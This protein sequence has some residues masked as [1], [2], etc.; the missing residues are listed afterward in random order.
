MYRQYLPW[1][2]ESAKTLIKTTQENRLPSKKIKVI[3]WNVHK[4]NHKYQ[5]LGDFK[6]ILN[7][8]QLDIILFQEYKK[9]SKRS[10]LSKDERYGYCFLANI[11]LHENEFGLMNASKANIIHHKALISN[12]VEPI[13]K[14]P[15]SILLTEYKMLDCRDLTVINV[16]LV[17]FVKLRSFKSELNRL[18][19]L[20]SV[21]TNPLILAGDFNTWSARRMEW[22]L[23]V[24]DNLGLKRVRFDIPKKKLKLLRELDHIFYRDLT[25]INS[26]LLLDI[27][28]SDH[29]PQIATF[30]LI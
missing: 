8:Y 28:S 25:L 1:H 17:N 10:I 18:E 13:I 7:H 11:M 4:E 20:A 23:K 22:L 12:T 14:T 26:T 29:S 30:N 2:I 16:H 24:C 3:N 15:K 6:E 5:W 21:S 19:E 27:K 9:I